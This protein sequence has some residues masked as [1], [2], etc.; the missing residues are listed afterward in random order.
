[1]LLVYNWTSVLQSVKDTWVPIL[2][3][4]AILFVVLILIAIIRKNKD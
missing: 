1:M 3:P 2:I 4:F